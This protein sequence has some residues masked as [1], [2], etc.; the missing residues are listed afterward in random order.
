MLESSAV[1]TSS[2]MIRLESLRVNRKRA[3]QR[4]KAQLTLAY[5]GLGAEAVADCRA[6]HQMSSRLALGPTRKSA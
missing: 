6:C 3:E 2:G 5:I 1:H 4:D